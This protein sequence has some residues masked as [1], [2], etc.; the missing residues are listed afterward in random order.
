[1]QFEFETPSMTA[2]ILAA[3]TPEALDPILARLTQSTA[4]L[5][6]PDVRGHKLFVKGLD[7]TI[8]HI[9]RTLRLADCEGEKSNDNVCVI[10]TQLYGV[11]GHSKV[12]ADIT[13]LIGG[14]K[15]SLILTDLYGNIPYRRLIGE[16]LAARGYH[17]RALLALKAPNVLDRTVELYRLLCAVKPTRIFLLHHHMDVCAV[18][19]TYP[20]RDVTEFVHHADHLP[21]LG[22]TVDYSAHVDLTYTCHPIC[23]A[24][25]L[26]PTYSGMTLP[27]VSIVQGVSKAEGPMV[28]GTCG[29]IG[30]YRREGRASRYRWV[31]WVIPALST[32]NSRFIHIGPTDAAFEQ[33]VRQG[34]ADAGLDP[35]RYVFTGATPNLQA[36][37]ISHQVDVYVSSYP[38]GGGRATLEAMAA[39]VPAVAPSEAE[40]G[41]LVQYS[42]PLS[43]WTLVYDPA[44]LPAAIADAADRRDAMRSAPY[45]A[46]VQAE[47]ERFEHYVAGRALGP[48]PIV[49]A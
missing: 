26:N 5:G 47:L 15:V 17:C 42:S 23:A 29:N 22:A 3:Q 4:P 34:L 38:E 30:K 36:A 46:T 40:M 16:D 39:G 49:Q 31:D 14:D 20:F 35:Q 1:M 10:A 43:G 32:P 44:E 11:G 25:G 13:R 21:S 28:F 45:R 18:A 24:A 41:P 37:L 6:A 19:A 2:E 27:D 12:V 8:P 7:G 48:T 9:A 33:E